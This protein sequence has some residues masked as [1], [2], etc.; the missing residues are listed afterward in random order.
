MATSNPLYTRVPAAPAV[1]VLERSKATAKATVGRARAASVAADDV[2]EV[3][4]VDD[5]P[6]MRA[7]IRFAL[8]TCPDLK[9]V[10]EAAT[11][12]EALRLAPV[13][14]PSVILMD[15]AM[16]GMG[17]LETIRALRRQ[18]PGAKVVVL[19]CID[20]GDPVRDALQAGVTGYHLK[21]TAMDDL[22]RAIRL[23]ARNEQTLDPVAARMLAEATTRS[24]VLSEELTE[25]E[26]EV[27]GLL[28]QGLR[29]DAIAE[30]LVV[31]VATIKFHV[32]AIRRKLR[33]TSRAHI[34]SLAMRHHLVAA[35]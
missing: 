22:V 13:L 29:N 16:P 20:G 14:R 30:Q 11:G 28:V 10:G 18:A 12:E 24:P 9:V 35:G 2:A 17:G 25:R 8:Q 15:M 32:R 7:G 6:V 21:G 27:L 33:A 31:T 4:V 5:H 3:L 26:R 1:A 19:T 34:V 23:A